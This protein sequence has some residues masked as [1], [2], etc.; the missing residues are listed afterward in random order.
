MDIRDD[1]EGDY[2]VAYRSDSVKIQR[3][4]PTPIQKAYDRHPPFGCYRLIIESK[5]IIKIPIFIELFI[6]I[7]TRGVA[8]MEH[9]DFRKSIVFLFSFSL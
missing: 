6:I 8:R 3:F 7:L 4:V 2:A 9:S 1:N 5:E